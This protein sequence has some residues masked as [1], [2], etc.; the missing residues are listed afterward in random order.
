MQRLIREEFSEHT[1][2]A[3][4]HRLG[5]VADFDQVLELKDGGLVEISQLKERG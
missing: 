5:A 2:I 3:I 4:S 1:V